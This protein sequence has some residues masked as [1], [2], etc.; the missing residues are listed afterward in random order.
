M[1]QLTA[2]AN[3][4]QNVAIIVHIHAHR[5]KVIDTLD[6]VRFT[7]LSE[8]NCLFQISLHEKINTNLVLAGQ[9]LR[10]HFQNLIKLNSLTSN[11][12]SIAH[13]QPLFV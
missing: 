5:Q 1:C 11:A 6:V 7:V 9:K 12:T 3:D 13:F 8:E 2:H 4:F 10:C